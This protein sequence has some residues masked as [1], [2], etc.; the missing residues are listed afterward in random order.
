MSGPERGWAYVLD[1]GG[2]H[3]VPSA[4][5]VSHDQLAGRA[6]VDRPAGQLTAQV[7]HPHRLPQRGAHRPVVAPGRVPA[8]AE[9]ILE[10][11]QQIHQQVGAP[12]ARASDRRQVGRTRGELASPRHVAPE[13]G[14]HCVQTAAITERL[15]QHAA[16]LGTG[17]RYEVVR[18]FQPDP[19]NPG[20]QHGVVSSEPERSRDPVRSIGEVD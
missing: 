16:H 5:R 18:P 10:R 3:G 19:S 20:C 17:R 7:G 2:Q 8:L 1:I 13:T 11:H 14:D 12:D 6:D 4:G 9:P 15:E